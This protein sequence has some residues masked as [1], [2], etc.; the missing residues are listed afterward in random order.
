MITDF[1]ELTIEKVGDDC[2]HLT[3]YHDGE[4]QTVSV[5]TAQIRYI[6]EMLGLIEGV[7]KND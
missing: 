6:A 5:H 7:N 4:T 1:P 2:L 3:Q